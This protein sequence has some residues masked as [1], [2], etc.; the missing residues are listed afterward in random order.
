MDK[1]LKMNLN[2]GIPLNISPINHSQAP[3]LNRLKAKMSIKKPRNIPYIPIANCPNASMAL[4][5]P[6][7]LIKREIQNTIKQIIPQSI[8]YPTYLAKAVALT[9]SSKS[10]DITKNSDTIF[11]PTINMVFKPVNKSKVTSISTDHLAWLPDP[12]KLRTALLDHK[13]WNVVRD[14]QR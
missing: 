1:N 6:V 11:E 2:V 4:T 13:Y 12:S 7:R 8:K 9:N 3:S 14:N 5:G 10:I